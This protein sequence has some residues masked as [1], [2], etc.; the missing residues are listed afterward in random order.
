MDTVVVHHTGGEDEGRAQKEDTGNMSHSCRQNIQV[1]RRSRTANRNGDQGTWDILQS[2]D[3]NVP[4]DGTNG[5]DVNVPMDGT[6]G[7]DVNAATLD[8]TNTVIWGATMSMAP[9]LDR[10]K[11]WI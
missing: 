4:M 1:Q 8:G 3:L 6:K 10:D 11:V 5:A 7:V 9:V 2:L